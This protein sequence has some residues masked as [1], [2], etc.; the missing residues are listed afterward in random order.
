[1]VCLIVGDAN[2]DLSASL[3]CFPR[4]GDD[5]AIKTLGFY[6]GGTGANVAV[7]FA[8]LGGLAR[9]VSRVGKDPAAE[10]ALHAARE[11][12]VDLDFVQFD[13]ERAT[14][15]CLAAISPSGERTFFSYRGANVAL[16]LPDFDSVFQ[17]V[18]SLHL[19][20]HALLAD[21]Q[22][23]TALT[24][25]GEARRRGIPSSLD[26][27]LPLLRK[28]PDEIQTLAPR[29]NVVFANARELVQLGS[30]LGLSNGLAGN[31]TEMVEKTLSALIDLGIP[32]VVAKLGS[33][34]SRIAQ[35][36][37]R[38]DIPPM[39]VAT[40]DTTGAGDGF[41]AGFLYM[42]QRGGTPQV[43]AEVGNVIGALVAESS[44]AGEACPDRKRVIAALVARGF[45]KALD[46]FVGPTQNTAS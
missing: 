11:S 1:M 40:K 18:H 41:V 26:L 25:L 12:G 42:L 33:S 45:T 30:S 35:N 7:A 29:L 8:R 31:E 37:S 19:S 3:E 46:V 28:W 27:C 34:G 10:V 17:N 14:G 43:A 5:V 23:Q 21:L 22:R 2:A 38:M 9:L 6:S 16:N 4:E 32:L 20:G 36:S 15:L 13:S 44:G 24:L 39:P